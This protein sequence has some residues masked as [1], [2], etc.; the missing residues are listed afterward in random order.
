MVPVC[1]SWS[2]RVFV[3]SRGVP[4]LVPAC[5]FWSRCVFCWSRGVPGLVPACVCWSRCD[6]VRVGLVLDGAAF[7]PK[8]SEDILDK[9]FGVT[10]HRV[11]NCSS[12]CCP[13]FEI[14]DRTMH[15]VPEFADV[16]LM[17]ATSRPCPVLYL[18]PHPGPWSRASVLFF[19]LVPAARLMSRRRAV[20]QCRHCAQ[21]PLCAV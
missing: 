6:P 14:E 9:P 2:R 19:A 8:V 11:G 16:P 3:W 20:A 4:G 21:I 13:E 10:L 7:D 1:L 18:P 15:N 5:V 12:S 17:A